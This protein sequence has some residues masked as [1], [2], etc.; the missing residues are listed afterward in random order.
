MQSISGAMQQRFLGAD[1]A[2]LTVIDV[3]AHF[4]PGDDWLDPYPDLAK[5]LPKLDPGAARGRRDRR[6][7]A[8]RRRPPAQ[9]PPFDAAGAAGLAVLFGQEKTA[10]KRAARR[11]RRQ[12]PVP[13]RERA[14][15]LE[16]DG[17]AGHPSPERDLPGR[18]RLPGVQVEDLA[19]APGSD[20]HGE[21]LAG[22][23][24]CRGE[25]AAAAGD[26]AGVQ[27]D[28]TGRVE[29]LARMRR[30]GSRIF[31]IPAYPVNGV[32]PIHPSWDRVC[33]Q[34]ATDARHG[35]DAAYRL[36]AHALRSGLGEPRRRSHADAHV[37][38]RHRHVAPK[39]LL[40][41]HGLQRRVRALSEADGAARG[42]RH[43]LAAVHVPGDRRPD[44][45]D[46]EVVPR[47]VPACREAERVPRAQREGDAALRRQRP[48]LVASWPS[49]RRRCWSS[50]RTSR[51]SRVSP[52]RPTTSAARWRRAPAA[53]RAAFA[54]RHDGGRVRA[55]GAA[56]DALI[57]VGRSSGA[58]PKSIVARFD[59]H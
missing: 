57:R 22:R 34:A 19:S 8:A 29:E 52:I 31:L 35:A 20:P 11:V 24:L 56:A 53:E 54:R 40:N 39:T 42:S 38:Q 18:H 14:G 27:L 36:R 48:P 30:R 32:P 3:D 4:E 47:Q 25:R 15:A 50:R 28:S 59:E 58:R 49:C 46:R 12:E 16:V 37:R 51:T 55:D 45:A 41:A 26:G 2:A 23:H 13:G 7:P 6:R 17:R 33:G 10:R 44:L 1:A 5:R 43:R 9:R 21:H